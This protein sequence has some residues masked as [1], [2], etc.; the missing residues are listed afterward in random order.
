MVFKLIEGAQK[1]RRRVDG[2]TQL[3]KRIANVKFD[4]RRRGFSD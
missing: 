3:P 4:A 1:T 2:Q